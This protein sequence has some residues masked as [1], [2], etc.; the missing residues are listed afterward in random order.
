MRNWSRKNFYNSDEL[1]L[2]PLISLSLSSLAFE[3]SLARALKHGFMSMS[4]LSRPIILID[5][6]GTGS[7]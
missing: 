6:L 5:P 4:L 1:L 7:W 3:E 2:F